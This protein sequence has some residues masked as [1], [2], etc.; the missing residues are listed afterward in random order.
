MGFMSDVWTALLSDEA[1]EVEEAIERISS[2]AVAS[3]IARATLVTL[4]PSTNEGSP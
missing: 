3:A 1:I 2:D 4:D